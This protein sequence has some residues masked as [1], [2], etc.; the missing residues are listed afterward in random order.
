[1]KIYSNAPSTAK[2]PT[3]GQKHSTQREAAQ[4]AREREQHPVIVDIST[5]GEEAYT[6]AHS[7][8]GVR[9]HE[10]ANPTAFMEVQPV[11]LF[12]T[13][14]K[15]WSLNALDRNEC[16]FATLAKRLENMI[17]CRSRN[18][19]THG[20]SEDEM[21]ILLQR[22]RTGFDQAVEW[23]ADYTARSIL[24]RFGD[25]FGIDL[26]SLKQDILAVGEK[27]ANHVFDGGSLEHLA[28]RLNSNNYTTFSF[29]DLG[30]L[31]RVVGTLDSQ[32]WDAIRELEE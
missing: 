26:E 10:N 22:V 30:M 24:F 8:S 17:A 20:L 6:T 27:I 5:E 31:T 19:A 13:A 14:F 29:S 7:G 12:F 25:D 18:G 3:Y 28:E 2:L 23:I 4:S 16:V 1:M 32:L 11:E 9:V 21:E 15:A